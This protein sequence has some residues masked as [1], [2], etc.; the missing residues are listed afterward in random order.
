[1]RRD[2]L[3]FTFAGTLFGFALGYMGASWGLVPRPPAAAAAAGSASGAQPGARAIDPNEVQALELLASRAPD[4]VSSRVELGNLYMDHDR[5]DDA[6]RWYRE[7]VALDP[8]SVAV[9]TD[10]GAC[11][12]GAGRPADGLAEFERALQIDAAYAGALYNKGLALVQLGRVA[13]GVATWESLLELHP[14]DP[15][16]QGLRA[17]IERLRATEGAGA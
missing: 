16:L 13:E 6:I 11:L 1:L 8:S 9:L 10:L 4:D 12:V 5:W 17:R 14:D 2:T 7:A 3:V 15:R